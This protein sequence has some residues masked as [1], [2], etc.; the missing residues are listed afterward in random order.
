M[1]TIYLIENLEKNM[2][3][4]A[5]KTKEEAISI[6]TKFNN[7]IWVS[8][9]IY[10]L[11]EGIVNEANPKFHK[12]GCHQPAVDNTKFPPPGGGSAVKW[13]FGSEVHSTELLYN[14]TIT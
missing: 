10:N 7:Y 4:F 6:C 12:S 2:T 5:V 3:V 13:N 11:N 9:P 14:N 1:E 8:L